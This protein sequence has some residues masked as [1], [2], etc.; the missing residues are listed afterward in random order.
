MRVV[1]AALLMLAAGP[2][3]SVAHAAPMAADLVQG[4]LVAEPRAVR[5]GEPFTVAVRLRMAEHWHTYWR[6][7]GDSGLA[8]EIAWTLPP[9]F[10]AGPIQWPAPQRLHCRSKPASR[11]S[12]PARRAAR[13]YRPR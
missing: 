8:T 10:S 11:K 9:G 7:P 3:G 5:G 6:N 12:F 1:L 2:F 4:V 13:Q